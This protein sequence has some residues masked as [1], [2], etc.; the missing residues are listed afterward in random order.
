MTSCSG[1]VPTKKR[2]WLTYAWRDNETENINYLIQELGNH[3]LDVQYDRA[4]LLPG[5]PLW[6][7]LD[8]QIDWKNID[9][10]AIY[11]TRQSLESEP[12][13]EEF[14]YAL[15]IA[16][17]QGR[18]SF[19]LIGIFPEP[20]DSEFIPKAI[21]TRL[22]VPL[23]SPTAIQDIVDGVNGQKTQEKSDLLPIGFTWHKTSFGSGVALE[24]W[25]RIGSFSKV[26]V[27][28]SG[29]SVNNS[30]PPS[31]APFVGTR[32]DPGFKGGNFGRSGSN[33]QSY[34]NEEFDVVSAGTPLSHG[35]SASV[36]VPTTITAE[37][38]M[39]VGGI[40]ASGNEVMI[41]VPIPQPSLAVGR[42]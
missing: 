29:L 1:D 37:T 40:D 39:L 5:R 3:G 42:S 25:P 15:N 18:V 2:L 26:I 36:L 31:A 20:V 7:Q 41:E 27:A 11:V 19:P 14:S 10:W 8:Q 4:T 6:D 23:D 13:R 12:C 24:F 21:S 28:Y 22:Y 33:I 38:R 9:A 32:G 34:R 35:Q 17:S 30:L 16:L